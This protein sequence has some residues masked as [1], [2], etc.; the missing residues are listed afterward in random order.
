MGADIG[1]PTPADFAKAF[2]LCDAIPLSDQQDR[3]ACYGGFGKEFV[4]FALGRDIR[5]S[6][7]GA[8]TDVQLNRVYEWCLLADQK[9]GSAAC[10]NYAMNSLYWGGEN[11]RSI[12][13]HFCDIMTDS[14]YQRSCF[15]NLIGAV[16]N[17]VEDQSY[18]RDFCEELPPDY[19]ENCQARLQ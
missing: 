1:R 7:A 13:T 6:T 4:V 11:D 2:P 16:S 17:Y 19:R 14:Y 9:Q 3:N 12:A 8:I 10:L 5:L 15:F 18:R